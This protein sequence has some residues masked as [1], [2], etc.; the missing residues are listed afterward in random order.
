[1]DG[2]NDIDME[3]V[4][5]TGALRPTRILGLS[6]A[7]AILCGHAYAPGSARARVIAVHRF[8]YV[9]TYLDA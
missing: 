5:K 8:P 2:L 9:P 4:D 3:L 7:H 6:P 1:M